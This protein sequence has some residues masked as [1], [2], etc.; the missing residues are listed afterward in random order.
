[1]KQF[2]LGF[3]LGALTVVGV[4]LGIG[5]FVAAS[6]PLA[7]ADAIVAISGD[8]SGTRVETAVALWRARYAPLLVFSGAS[9]DP[10]SV[11]SAELMKREA[12]RGGVPEAAVVVEPTAATTEENGLRVAEIM[13]ARGLHS[14]ILVT[15][16]YH[17]RRAA[18]LFARAFAPAGMT[19][20]NHPAD[21]PDWDANT[22][23]AREPSRT[24]TTR[25]LV[26]LGLVIAGAT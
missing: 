7:P 6:D 4:L 2:V 20:R 1:V 12:L 9:L 14:A 26:K 18:L 3:V 11:S 17:Q 5:H 25:E 23:W 13:K 8:A 10:A 22:W 19:F 16:P 15:S 21:D 24:L